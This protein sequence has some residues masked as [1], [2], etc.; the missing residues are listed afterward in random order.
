MVIWTGD[1][2]TDESTKEVDAKDIVDFLS[3]VSKTDVS[4][5]SKKEV[6][7]LIQ[8]LL[9]RVVQYEMVC[10]KTVELHKQDVNS[11]HFLGEIEAC[12]HHCPEKK[13]DCVHSI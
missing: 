3:R 7:D 5:L 10:G 11:F 4:K 6:S 8:L 13:S 12:M 2:S 9:E 1:A